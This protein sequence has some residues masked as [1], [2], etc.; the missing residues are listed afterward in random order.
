[1]SL[2]GTNGFTWMVGFIWVL[3]IISYFFECRWCGVHL[4]YIYD[5]PIINSM[6]YHEYKRIEYHVI[7]FL[8]YFIITYICIGLKHGLL[9]LWLLYSFFDTPIQ[10]GMTCIFLMCKIYLICCYPILFST[11]KT[12]HIYFTWLIIYYF[13]RCEK[14]NCYETY[15]LYNKQNRAN[16]AI[17]S[18]LMSSIY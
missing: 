18:W 11:T 12:I 2:S 7:V 13:S 4:F 17:K 14:K 16:E 1:M 9:F 5:R 6:I 10:F 15:S 3:E 8:E